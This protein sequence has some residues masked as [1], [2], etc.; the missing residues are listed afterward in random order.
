[1]NAV[2]VTK[3]RTIQTIALPNPKRELAKDLY[4]G[5]WNAFIESGHDVPYIDNM[6]EE[7]VEVVDFFQQYR[8]SIALK[9]ETVEA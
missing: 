1:M 6:L 3:G 8:D 4:S 2:T 7:L 5:V 9:D